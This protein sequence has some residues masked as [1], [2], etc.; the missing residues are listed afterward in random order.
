MFMRVF[1]KIK[2]KRMLFNKF[3]LILHPKRFLEKVD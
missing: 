3:V 1:S 2:E